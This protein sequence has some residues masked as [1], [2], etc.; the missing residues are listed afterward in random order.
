MTLSLLSPL[1]Q[2]VYREPWKIDLPGGLPPPISWG[3][4]FS[5]RLSFFKIAA[6]F[7]KS[8]FGRIVDVEVMPVSLV[9]ML[10]VYWHNEKRGELAM[11]AL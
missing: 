11:N 2:G 9:E 7:R 6:C 3:R 4:C 1:P 10:L 8:R 5:N